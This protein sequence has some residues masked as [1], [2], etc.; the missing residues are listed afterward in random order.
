MKKTPT[1]L[2][3]DIKARLS[4][5]GIKPEIVDFLTRKPRDP[6]KAARRA[7]A[8]RRA[9]YTD[10]ELDTQ[11]V[12][13]R[14]YFDMQDKLYSALYKES[15]SRERISLEK[16]DEHISTGAARAH[17]SENHKRIVA[18]EAE[19]AK[20]TQ[21]RDAALKARDEMLKLYADQQAKRGK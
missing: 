14:K 3:H 2:K 1:K 15:A 13:L 8:R 9:G 12:T 4:R 18:L 6:E 20:L 11:T 5:D 21:E 19:V 16:M 17:Q 10:Q 7:A